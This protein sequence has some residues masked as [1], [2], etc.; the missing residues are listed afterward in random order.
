MIW[1][2][3]PLRHSASW[4]GGSTCSRY[5]PFQAIAATMTAMFIC[6]FLS[7][8]FIRGCRKSRSGRWS[9]TGSSRG[10]PQ[11]R[12]HPTMGGACSSWRCSGRR[13]CGAT[14]AARSSSPPLPSPRATASSGYLDDYL[15]IIES[16]RR[17]CRPLQTDRAVP[18]RDRRHHVRVHRQGHV[19]SD[20]WDIRTRVSIPFVAFAK[21]PISL[22]LWAYIAFAVFTVVAT[23]NAVNFTDGLDGLAIGPV[24]FNAGTY[25]VWAYLSAASFRY[26]QRRAAF[27]VAHY[28]DIPGSRP[29]VRS[30][31]LLRCARRGR[32]RIPSGTT[33]TP[34]RCSWA[35][36][37]RSP[38]AAARHLRR[39][40]KTELLSIILGGIFFLEGLSVVTQIVSF[41]LTGK[42]VF[43]M[44]PIHHHYE[45]KGWPEPKI[46]FAS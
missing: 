46:T 32:H 10:T 5:V 33:R 29:R 4:L 34:R 37:A 11:K 12:G 41:R 23:S 39:V 42:R 36:S 26:R 40:P 45:K 16:T 18:R 27:I 25:L 44:A 22:P 1:L 20:W 15:K 3:I 13:S 30:L 7:P 43:L 8:W 9:A 24:I 35:T 28:L 19:P 2:S 6:F 31:D 17:G 21:H 38:S 14:F